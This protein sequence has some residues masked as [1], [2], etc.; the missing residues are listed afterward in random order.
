MQ[1]FI[2]TLCLIGMI[3]FFWALIYSIMTKP[4]QSVPVPEPKREPPPSPV[5][6]FCSVCHAAAGTMSREQYLRIDHPIYC[7][8]CVIPIEAYKRQ[9]AAR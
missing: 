7:D 5:G 6:V 8:W 1:Q 9:Q 2:D 4:K 3:A